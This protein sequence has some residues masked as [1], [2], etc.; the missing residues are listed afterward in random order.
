[1]NL[2][3]KIHSKTD[4]TIKYIFMT[5]DNLIIELSYI[6]KNDGKDIICV[7]SQT[8]CKM[9]CKFC[10]ITDATDKLINRNLTSQEIKDSIDNV[11]NDL[12]LSLNPKPLLISYMGCGEP[13]L[14]Y[15]QVKDSMLLLRNEYQT[16]KVPLI[17]FAIATSLPDFAWIN[18]F[19]L[20]NEIHKEK[21]PV[22]IHLSLHYTMDSLRKD[23]MPNSLSI[24]PSL[25]ALEY[26]KKITKNSVEIHYTLIN[27]VNDTER[28]AIRLSEFLKY[29][30]IPVK[31]LFYNEKPSIEFHASSKEKLN[32]FKRYFD[33]YNIEY[34]YYIPPGLDVGASCGQFLMDYYLKYNLVKSN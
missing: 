5:Q 9:K 19:N 1:M 29:R 23:W 3:E 33:K 11:Y 28:D 30:D 13:L 27:G 8:S 7:P 20:T 26:Y 25:I 32:I 6:N 4:N 17:R 31:F 10:H 34:E 24:L 21:L 12:N 14:N 18:F 2:L 15:K 16:T 22:K